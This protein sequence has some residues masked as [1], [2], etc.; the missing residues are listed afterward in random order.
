MTAD[1]GN[2]QAARITRISIPFMLG[3]MVS[4]GERPSAWRPA[5]HPPTG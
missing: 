2:A 5:M 1:D 3:A 4:S